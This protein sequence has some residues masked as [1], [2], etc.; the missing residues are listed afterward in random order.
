MGIL[1]DDDSLIDAALSE[2]LALPLE[3]RHE[4]DPLRGVDY[5]LIQHHLGQ[6]SSS[7]CIRCSNFLTRVCCE[8]VMWF[9]RSQ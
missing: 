7:H 4:L 6:V 2:I 3:R 1:T 5:F 8:R 9:K